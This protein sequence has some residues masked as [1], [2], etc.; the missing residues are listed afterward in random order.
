MAHPLGIAGQCERVRPD[1]HPRRQ[2]A[3]HRRLLERAADN[4][5]QHSGKQIEQSKGQ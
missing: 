2:I 1:Q 4:H 5:G 3:Q